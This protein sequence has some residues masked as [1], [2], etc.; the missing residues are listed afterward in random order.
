MPMMKISESQKKLYKSFAFP[1]KQA[2][3]TIAKEQKTKKASLIGSAVGTTIGLGLSIA[4]ARKKEPVKDIFIKNDIKKTAKNLLKFTKLD[5]E[6]FMG[7]IYMILQAAGASFGSL[8][9]G[10][11]QD[12]HKESRIEKVKEAVFVMNNVAIPTACAKAVE[13]MLSKNSITNK[14]ELLKNIS[15]NKLLKNI[16][17]VSGLMVGLLGSLNISN[18][19]NTKIIEPDDKRKKTINPTDFL[20]HVDDIVP[21]LASSKDSIF[22][23][24]PLD[25][26]MPLIYFLLG[27]EIGEKNYYTY[28]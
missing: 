3:L 17:V 26:C 18:Y 12:K 23:G 10:S 5:Y 25:R 8:I 11:W 27:S 2:Y 4:L 9:A 16:A 19:I 21:I 20:V 14:S 13:H 6:G 22:K 7:Y 1:E 15:K 28:E 24:L